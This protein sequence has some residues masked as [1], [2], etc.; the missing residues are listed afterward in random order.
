[1]LLQIFF[2]KFHSLSRC[3]VITWWQ[4]QHPPCTVIFLQISWIL[5][6]SY[7]ITW[8][9]TSCE[10]IAVFWDINFDLIYVINL[11]LWFSN[12]IWNYF[13]NIS[14]HTFDHPLQGLSSI[15]IQQVEIISDQHTNIVF[16]CAASPNMILTMQ[17]FYW[18]CCSTKFQLTLI[19]SRRLKLLLFMYI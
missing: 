12:T 14:S 10:I 13:N 5:Q 15:H 8:Y 17:Q 19:Y 4:I 3:S 9:D 18:L 1:M 16:E 6:I 2:R 11:Q 7:H